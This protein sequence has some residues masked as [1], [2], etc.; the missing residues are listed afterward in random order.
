MSDVTKV[1]IGQG[2]HGWFLY[3]NDGPFDGPY[4]SRAEAV[5]VLLKWERE[6]Y[7]AKQQEA[8][9]TPITR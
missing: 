6:D 8:S 1:S 7:E 9:L 4:A 5:A 2:S 3:D